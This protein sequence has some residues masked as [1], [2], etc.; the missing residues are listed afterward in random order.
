MFLLGSY[1]ACS[2]PQRVCLRWNRGGGKT[3]GEQHMA[4][5]TAWELQGTR[6]LIHWEV[7]QFKLAF[8]IN[9]QPA[10]TQY[11]H[12]LSYYRMVN[13][14]YI[15]N[16]NTHNNKHYITNYVY[17]YVYV[18]E[19]QALALL[20]S[21]EGIIHQN[22]AKPNWCFAREHKLLFFFTLEGVCRQSH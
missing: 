20:W 5:L 1:V 14:L 10:K 12:P 15:L 3:V 21:T 8:C 7:V 16:T 9:G 4:K 2:L 19:M 17:V 18:L 13:I 6:V 11:L 22:C